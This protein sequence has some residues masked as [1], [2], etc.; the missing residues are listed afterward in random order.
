MKTLI[1][2]VILWGSV[3]S[4]NADDIPNSPLMAQFKSDMRSLMLKADAD[5]SDVKM[6]EQSI[7][8]AIEKAMKKTLDTNP[9]KFTTTS[10]EADT[11]A[12]GKDV[13]TK[14]QLTKSI[15][16]RKDYKT[17][18]PFPPLLKYYDTLNANDTINP[19]QRVIAFRLSEDSLE[20][21]KERDAIQEKIKKRQ[22]EQGQ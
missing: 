1:V 2:A 16:S 9:A 17:I 10:K 18:L 19:Y 6:D 8:D 13:I 15:Q 14:D 11:L 5:Y 3:S 21:A 7:N 22:G 20:K 12:N 4:V